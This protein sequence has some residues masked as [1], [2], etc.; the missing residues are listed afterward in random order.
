MECHVCQTFWRTHIW[1]RP[2][3]RWRMMPRPLGLWVHGRDGSSN[4]AFK[5]PNHLRSGP[6]SAGTPVMRYANARCMDA[7][8][9]Q[10][11]FCRC[12]L[13]VRFVRDRV[14]RRLS[15]SWYPPRSPCQPWETMPT[16]YAMELTRKTYSSLLDLALSAK[17][18]K[19]DDDVIPG[20]VRIKFSIFI[21]RIFDQLRVFFPWNIL[22]A[23]RG[24]SESSSLAHRHCLCSTP[25]FIV[26]LQFWN[27]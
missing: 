25:F 12:F 18:V 1:C 2:S 4:A 16:M 21:P 27:H 17:K 26:Y 20:A 6:Y 5:R 15:Y 22:N 24:S 19:P 7:N 14:L 10:T 8:H 23:F 9:G 11:T 13:L 3:C